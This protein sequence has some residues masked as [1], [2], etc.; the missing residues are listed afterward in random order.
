[1][2]F[3]FEF[4][5]VAPTWVCC[6][7]QF[8]LTAVQ[9]GMYASPRYVTIPTPP[10]HPPQ[11]KGMCVCVQLGMCASLRYVTIP[12][13]PTHPPQPKGMCVCVQLG[14]YASPRYVTI[15]T[16]PTHPPQRYVC[17]HVRTDESPKTRCV[18]R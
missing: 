1:M 11:P 16:P 13:P 10:T 12:T 2:L 3:L 9:L 18:Y 17:V 5:C 15:P 4:L 7:C 14:M 6:M 8:V